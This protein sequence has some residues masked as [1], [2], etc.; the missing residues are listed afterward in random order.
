MADLSEQ[1]SSTHQRWWICLCHLLWQGLR[2][3]WSI[4]V[5]GLVLNIVAPLI[6]LEDVI[7]WIVQNLLIAIPLSIG[8]ILL[9]LITGTV[10]RL[11]SVVRPI[12]KQVKRM[13]P[14]GVM[15]VL[16]GIAIVSL[17]IPVSLSTVAI[18]LIPLGTIACILLLILFFIQILSWGLTQ[19]SKTGQDQHRSTNIMSRRSFLRLTYLSVNVGVAI[20]SGYLIAR[21]QALLALLFPP[22]IIVTVIYSTEKEGWLRDAT[23]KFNRTTRG[24]QVDLVD[25]RGSLDAVEKILEGVPDRP[26]VWS[27]ASF[28]ELHLLSTKWK[29]KYPDRQEIVTYTDPSALQGIVHSPLVFAIWQSRA[30]V[31]SNALTA[32]PPYNAIDWPNIHDILLLKN[33]SKIHGDSSWGEVKFG[34]TQPDLSNSGLLAITL[35]AYAYFNDK[36]SKLEPP[37]SQIPSFRNSL[38]ILRI[39]YGASARALAHLWTPSSSAVPAGSTLSLLMRIWFLRESQ[40]QQGA[41]SLC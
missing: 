31:L 13:L 1:H 24:I 37:I 39:R 30:N 18:T 32:S 22:P 35:M 29:Q 11:H 6:P 28:L 25:E 14:Y 33:W 34:Q 38:M 8:I 7:K 12:I 26:T 3:F 23:D 4:I 40:R 10:D 9:T 21:L 16:I 15:V 17:L 5:V 27:P 19:P 2:Y 20:A 41:M 36:E